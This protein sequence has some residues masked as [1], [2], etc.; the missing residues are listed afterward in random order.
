M[1]RF[2]STHDVSP[3]M[4]MFGVFV[5]IS[6]FSFWLA[7]VP[8]AAADPTDPVVPDPAPAASEIEFEDVPQETRVLDE[9]DAMD[10]ALVEDR[11]VE[12]SA[13]T[14]E[15]RRVVADPELGQLVAEVSLLPERVREGGLWVDVDTSLERRSD[16][17]VTTGAAA[18]DL[19]LSGGSGEP[20][21]TLTSES[22]ASL[23][24]VWPTPL[25][26]PEIHGDVAVWANVAPGIDLAVKSGVTG[27]SQFLVVRTREAAADPLLKQYSLGL[28]A[29]GL[30]V[31]GRDGGF[32]AT[33]SAG[34]E[35]FAGAQLRM[36]EAPTEVTGSA[37]EVA[38]AVVSAPELQGARSAAV[39]LEVAGSEFVITPDAA[40]LA[41]PA[42]RFPVVI[43]PSVSE[44]RAVWGMVWNNGMEF[45][46]DS[47]EHARVGYDD[48]SGQNKVSRA[49]YRFD[50]TAFQG[51]TISSATMTH[52]QIHSTRDCDVSSGVPGVELWYTA[53]I[54]SSLTWSNQPEWRKELDT[55]TIAHG[56]SDYCPGS[57]PTEWDATEGAQIVAD[58]GFST[59][60]VGLKSANEGEKLGWRQFDN[61]S[62]R[63]VMVVVYN[64]TPNV[65]GAVDVVEAIDY[66]GALFLTDTTPTLKVN[67]SDPDANDSVHAVFIVNP[68]PLDTYD[69]RTFL[70]S[71]SVSNPG[72]ATKVVTSGVMV[73]GKSYYLYARA[74]D[75]DL[76]SISGPNV[77]VTVD[78]T[79]PSAP[80]ISTP[81][82]NP[83]VGSSIPISIDSASSDTAKYVWGLNT[84]T[85]S[86]VVEPGSLGAAVSVTATVSQFGP[87]FITA[88]SVDRAG[89]RSAVSRKEFKVDGTLPVRRYRLDGNGTD[90]RTNT[91]PTVTGVNLTIPTGTM[92]GEGHDYRDIDGVRDCTDKAFMASPTGTVKQLTTAG[93]PLSTSASFSISAWVKPTEFTT[94]AT[95]T[96]YESMALSI[97]TDDSASISLGYRRTLPTEPAYWMA[98][99]D[100]DGVVGARAFIHDEATRYTKAAASL[101]WTHLTVVW[102]NTSEVIQFYV[103]GALVASKSLVDANPFN[104]NQLMIGGAPLGSY[105]NLPWKGA[106]DE[107]LLYPGVL[108]GVQVA[109]AYG[110]QRDVVGC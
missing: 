98:M 85:P 18:S 5:A 14:S 86:T 31:R 41:D 65:P 71:P 35:V 107:V 89:N 69:D 43:D 60:T 36:W 19:E 6:L 46:N 45:W 29:P 93:D 52:S 2:P 97:F 99:T 70:S 44:T 30:T 84:D 22:D 21:A 4:R 103:N 59:F 1:N 24:F 110:L 105:G 91:A 92:W 28:V 96:G 108:D 37:G 67:V 49:F 63:P 42:T 88:Y 32:V 79:A 100:T 33:D 55:A 23:G 75:G 90:T 87:N 26:E 47:A 83:S 3:L 80:A 57:T 40:L 68:D 39:G 16:G 109:Q 62:T 48:W 9:Q 13:L 11:P 72:M 64:K 66:K 15:T 73:S 74:N 95:G 7:R 50:A 34:A 76:E 61:T 106:V 8:L 77:K 10:K 54:S 101:E 17:T 58:A 25:T 78:T 38:A 53:G 51:A 12:V 20:F 82:T 81:A 94:T 56:N 102:N 104:G 27:F